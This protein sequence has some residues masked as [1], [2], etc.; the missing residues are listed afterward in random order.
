MIDFHKLIISGIFTIRPSLRST[1]QPVSPL[2]H[3]SDN[4]DSGQ[5]RIGR[6]NTPTL[7]PVQLQSS[8]LCYIGVHLWAYFTTA[9]RRKPAVVQ[10]WQPSMGLQ[11]NT[12]FPALS[13]R[14]VTSPRNNA[15]LTATIQ[16][17]GGMQVLK[18]AYT[19]WPHTPVGPGH[20]GPWWGWRSGDIVWYTLAD[21]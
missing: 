15:I 8:A 20:Q 13:K 16:I 18:D 3:A 1:L 7:P 10:T 4:D 14:K 2:D 17:L 19:S 5:Q 6:K 11:A 12:F 21:V 9:L